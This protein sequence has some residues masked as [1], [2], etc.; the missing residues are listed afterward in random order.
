[1]LDVP[2]DAVGD[3]LAELGLLFVPPAA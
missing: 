2:V 1:M 3:K